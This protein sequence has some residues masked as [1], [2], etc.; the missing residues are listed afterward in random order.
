MTMM[1]TLWANSAYNKLVIFLFYLFIIFFFRKQEFDISC[2]L[3]PMDLHD[4]SCFL[5]K[6][7]KTFQNNIC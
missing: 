7:K 3:S 6:I 1:L 4:M 5:G 2:K